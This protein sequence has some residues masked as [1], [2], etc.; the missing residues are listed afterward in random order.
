MHEGL[1]GNTRKAFSVLTLRLLPKQPIGLI[2]EQVVALR[3]CCG[4]RE[5]RGGQMIKRREQ[6]IS[7]ITGLRTHR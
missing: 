2:G 6:C 3:A 7:R 5:I 4:L 1:S